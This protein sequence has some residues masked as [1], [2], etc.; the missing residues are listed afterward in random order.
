[1]IDLIILGTPIFLGWAINYAILEP[2]F[3]FE[4]LRFNH[5]FHGFKALPD[6]EPVTWQDVFET[7]TCAES[8]ALWAGLMKEGEEARLAMAK[9]A[10]E[11]IPD[12]SCDSVAE[13]LD[14]PKLKVR[15]LSSKSRRKGNAVTEYSREE[16]LAAAG[17]R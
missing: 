7:E 14:L 2:L 11:N 1:M 3:K 13:A 5:R 15:R 8:Q 6:Q 16:I 10:L 17:E 4:E 9:R 12:S